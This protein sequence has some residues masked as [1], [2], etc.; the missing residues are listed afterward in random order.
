[1][2]NN[3][4]YRENQFWK[5]PIKLIIYAGGQNNGM[6]MQKQAH[7]GWIPGSYAYCVTL[8]KLLKFL[9]SRGLCLL[10][11]FWLLSFCFT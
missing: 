5:T 2:F 6:C 10:G 7:L 9:S 1:M 11:L 4:D 8:N 3:Q